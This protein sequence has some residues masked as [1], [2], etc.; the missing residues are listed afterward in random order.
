[1]T[2]HYT[3][4]LVLLSLTTLSIRAQTEQGL[5]LARELSETRDHA[6]SAVEYR[7]LA[8]DHEAPTEQGALYWMAGYEYVKA[9]RHEQANRMLSQVEDAT[10]SLE[11]EVYLLRGENSCLQERFGEAVFYLESL[12]ESDQPDP[13]RRLAAQ[14]LAAVK[15]QLKDVPAAREALR[16]AGIETDHA[17]T[18]IA[19]YQAGKDKSPVVGGLLGLI[20][21]LGYA[22]SGEYASGLRSLILN[23]LCIWGVIE[24][25]EEEQWAGV[26]VV[27]FAELTFYSGSIYG[28]ADAAVR[29]ND[30]RLQQC[31]HAIDGGPAIRPDLSA[32]AVLTLRYEF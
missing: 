6:Q 29:Y 17:E 15:M 13:L 24:F 20:P 9:G 30:R 26:A 32:R 22:Y 3:I 19:T 11:T 8:M 28:G 1:M 4:G 21:G 31:T 27:G 14:R 5:T 2:K 16:R 23:S 18:A 12:D 7:R 25:A 10:P